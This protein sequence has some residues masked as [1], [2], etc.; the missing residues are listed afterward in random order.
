MKT[1]TPFWRERGATSRCAIPIMHSQRKCCRD[2]TGTRIDL[3]RNYMMMLRKFI[4]Q[5][6][7]PQ[8]P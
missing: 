3:I 8:A 4:R 5:G 2:E 1:G 7:L 6:A